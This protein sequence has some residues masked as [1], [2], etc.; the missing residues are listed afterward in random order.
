MNMVIEAI[1]K[2]FAS[3]PNARV[4]R[5]YRQGKNAVAEQMI[6]FFMVDELSSPDVDKFIAFSKRRFA[7]LRKMVAPNQ[8]PEEYAFFL[9]NYGGL[10]LVNEHDVPEFS[11]T[12]IGPGMEDWYGDIV[13][14]NRQ[15]SAI[16]QLRIGSWNMPI[17]FI[18]SGGKPLS[19]RLQRFNFYIDLAGDLEKDSIVTAGP[20]D[21]KKTEKEWNVL[22][23]SFSEWLANI[24]ETGGPYINA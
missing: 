13:E 18:Q 7:K 15:E 4:D 3:L 17:P 9:E 24:A 22:A 20:W 1:V 21:Y 12:G 8:L 10:C 2:K 16:R 11:L 5:N 23:A 19:P 14:A 6:D